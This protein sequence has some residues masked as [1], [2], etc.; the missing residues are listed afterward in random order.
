MFEQCVRG[1]R[2]LPTLRQVAELVPLALGFGAIAYSLD[3]DLI[4]L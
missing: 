3:P 1:L 4:D 2:T